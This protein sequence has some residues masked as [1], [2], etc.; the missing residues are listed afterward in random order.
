MKC[1]LIGCGRMGSA[2]AKSV[3]RK[4]IFNKNEFFVVE[5]QQKQQA[6]LKSLKINVFSKINEIKLEKRNFDVLILA[7]KPQV[8]REVTED[9]K[10]NI[11]SNYLLI[12]IAA[13]VT[14]NFFE[15]I[16]GNDSKVIRAMP[17][18]PAEI[19]KGITALIKSSKVSSNEKKIAEDIF[20]SMGKILWLQKENLMDIVTA[21]SGSG[22]AYIFYIVEIIVNAAVKAGLNKEL[23][24]MIVSEMVMGSGS[25]LI[26]SKKQPNVLR[27][28]VTSPGG[29]TEV[30]I[31]ILQSKNTFSSI[32]QKAIY[33]AIKKSEELSKNS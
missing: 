9:C 24:S 2:I 25:L 17:N 27:R 30:A 1:L 23:S 12:S 10:K 28:E 29:T 15:S 16:L 6:K 7:V 19:G 5:P 26:D 14:L 8:I 22:P 21:V 3:Y 31:N 18:T 4:K 32:I 33:S 13:G 11:N 20:N